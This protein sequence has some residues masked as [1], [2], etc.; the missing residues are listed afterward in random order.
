MPGNIL[1]YRKRLSGPI[2][3]R[4][5]LH[6]E[7]PPVEEEKLTGEFKSEPSDSIRKR[8]M[9]AGERQRKRLKNSAVKT[10][11]EMKTSDIKNLCKLSDE[12]MNFLKQA[13][14]RLSLS[15]RS[16]F[17]VLKIS[18]TI[19][20]LEGKEKIETAHVAEALQY[21]VKED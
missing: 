20:D 11:A 7:V 1:R 19:A 10:N 17:K 14:S 18:Q 8:I 2:L 21:R 13:I 6:V 3:D 15:A 16:Y 9:I 12:S 4:I 5:D